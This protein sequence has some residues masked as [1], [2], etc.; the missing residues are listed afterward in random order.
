MRRYIDLVKRE[1]MLFWNNSVLRMLFIGAPLA[2]G[3]LFGF[4][5]EKG[6]VT[7]LPI[8]VVDEDNS[9]MSHRLI[10]MLNDN[11]TV[12][13]DYDAA[14]TLGFKLGAGVMLW[15]KMSIGLDFYAL[16][17]AKISGKAEKEEGDYSVY[18]R[19]LKGK[20]DISSSEL[21]VRVGYHF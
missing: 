20:N 12:K 4:V 15:N 16:G 1:F 9:P 18:E 10:E 7:D 19:D 13:I 17:K 8:V 21:V 2:Y 14:T 6:K 11:E 3:I 5:Y